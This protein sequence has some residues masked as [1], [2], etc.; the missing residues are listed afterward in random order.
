MPIPIGHKL[1]R[2]I[3]FVLQ[4]A[5]AQALFGALEFARRPH[6]D[7]ADRAELLRGLYLPTLER[8]QDRLATDMETAGISWS[9]VGT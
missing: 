2:G 5:E 4:P 8:I 6:A 9:E 1:Y 7:G 3:H